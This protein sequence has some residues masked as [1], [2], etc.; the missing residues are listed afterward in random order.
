MD[1][2]HYWQAI[3]FLKTCPYVCEEIYGLMYRL[4][5]TPRAVVEFDIKYGR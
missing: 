1:K 2:E 3:E 4:W 5:G